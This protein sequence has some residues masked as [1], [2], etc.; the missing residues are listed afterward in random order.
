MCICIKFGKEWNIIMNFNYQFDTSLE[1]VKKS[2]CQFGNF[3]Q[4]IVHVVVLGHFQK[5]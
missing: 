3:L 5:W 1:C 2:L 4:P